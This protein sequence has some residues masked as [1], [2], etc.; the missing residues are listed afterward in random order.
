MKTPRE[1]LLEKHGAATWKLDAVRRRALDEMAAGPVPVGAGVV[2]PWWRGLLWR[3]A[4]P[5][6]LLWVAILAVH[7]FT[8]G[9]EPPDPGVTRLAA[10]VLLPAQ[11]PELVRDLLEFNPEAAA[12][13]VSPPR[14]RTELFVLPGRC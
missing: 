5:L 2:R 11:K 7:V 10:E 12:L 4:F 9:A 14:P 1:I 6:T 3:H 13:P 8:S